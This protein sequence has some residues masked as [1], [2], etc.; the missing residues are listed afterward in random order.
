MHLVLLLLELDCLLATIYIYTLI[1]NRRRGKRKRNRKKKKE[2]EK[3]DYI[4]IYTESLF[5]GIIL[6][7]YDLFV[8]PSTAN[9]TSPYVPLPNSLPIIYLEVISS[10]NVLMSTF[11]DLNM[12]SANA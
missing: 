11:V 1:I 6:I 9:R 4:I 7:A 3:E 12:N 2:E 8:N 5:F 10:G